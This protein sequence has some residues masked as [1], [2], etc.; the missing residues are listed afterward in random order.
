MKAILAALILSLGV[1]HAQD[2]RYWQAQP[3]ATVVLRAGELRI[4]AI[5]NG[6]RFLRLD[7]QANAPISIAAVVGT[8]LQA[9]QSGRAQTVNE[10][11][12]A[13]SQTQGSFRCT[14][15]R[16]GMELVILDTNGA[17][18]MDWLAALVGVYM[19]NAGPAMNAIGKASSTNT[20]TL[21]PFVYMNTMTNAVANS[22]APLAQA[23]A[24]AIASRRARKQEQ[25]AASSQDNP[26]LA[27]VLAQQSAAP[28]SAA[29]SSPESGF[30][31]VDTSRAGSN[32]T[33]ADY[34]A[35][36]LQ[37]IVLYGPV[38]GRVHYSLQADNPVSAFF[39]S[40]ADSRALA[41]NPGTLSRA[42]SQ[43]FCL[44]SRETKVS[45]DCPLTAGEWNFVVVN[46]FSS[47]TY[48]SVKLEAAVQPN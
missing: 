43:G 3:S 21:T 42:I 4:F 6:V 22:A 48:V 5:A 19:H 37:K 34:R 38:T 10:Y 31:P 36:S 9:Y 25:A 16:S 26:T 45:G 17:Q 41:E 18:G 27:Q 30:P 46:R 13:S 2:D 7:F 39:L 20:V 33:V 32:H 14:V 40:A 24:N 44:Q 15:P 29:P 11:C 35:L 12:P 8:E 28:T 1:A 47:Q 23:I